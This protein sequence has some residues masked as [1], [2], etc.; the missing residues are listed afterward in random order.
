MEKAL[1]MEHRITVVE[2][3]AKSNTR[4]IEEIEKR[5]DTLDELVVSMKALAI[6]EENVEKD[7]KEVKTTVKELVGK[8]GKRWDNFWDKLLIVAASAIVGF[9]LAKIGIQ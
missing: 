9:I 6:R 4:R 5:Q 8:S 7:V 1:E 2:D 3:K